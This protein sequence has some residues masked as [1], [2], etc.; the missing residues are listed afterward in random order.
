MEQGGGVG[1]EHLVEVFGLG[2]VGGR[3]GGEHVG[4]EGHGDAF[5][6]RLGGAPDL[7]ARLRNA[8]LL[9]A[10]VG[11]EVGDVAVEAVARHLALLEHAIDVGVDVLLVEL[12]GGREALA[13]GTDFGRHAV[14]AVERGQDVGEHLVVVLVVELERGEVGQG[15]GR[16]GVVAGHVGQGEGGAEVVAER[17]DERAVLFGIAPEPLAREHLEPAV[18]QVDVE[19]LR[20]FL[21]TQ[22]DGEGQQEEKEGEKL[23]FHGKETVIPEARWSYRSCRCTC[24]RRRCLWPSCP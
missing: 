14:L 18:L 8:E 13:D 3:V 16:R 24:R 21:G 23:L 6:L 12:E 15:V 22:G 20:G 11:E 17:D 19:V 2:V 9:P 1:I 7:V 5:H 4:G 10:V